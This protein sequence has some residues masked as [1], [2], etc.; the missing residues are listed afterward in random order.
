MLAFLFLQDLWVFRLKCR[1]LIKYVREIA[2]SDYPDDS[3][4]DSHTQVG[5]NSYVSRIFAGVMTAYRRLGH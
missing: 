3:D 1:L 2:L 5:K 4:I